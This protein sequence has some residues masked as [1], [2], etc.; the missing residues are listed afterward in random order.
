MVP[1]MAPRCR[2]GY[3]T[4]A[5]LTF[6]RTHCQKTTHLAQNVVLGYLMDRVTALTAKQ[7]RVVDEYLIDSNATQAAVRAG[8]SVKTAGAIGFENLKKPEIA[9]E[10]AKRQAALAEKSGITA[11]MVIGGLLKEAEYFGEGC[12]HAA[13]VSAWEKLGKHLG[14]FVEKVNVSGSLTLEQLVA[15]SMNKVDAG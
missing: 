12:S 14:M 4:N 10:V 5:A 8:Y 9:A 15:A 7:R 2:D 11:G 13:R 1:N 3:R 6:K